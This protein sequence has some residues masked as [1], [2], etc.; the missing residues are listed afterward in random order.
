MADWNA[1]YPAQQRRDLIVLVLVLV[2]EIGEI[3][4]ED[5]DEGEDGVAK[6][7]RVL[8]EFRG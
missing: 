6:H 2:I 8:D 5:E 3:E 7:I 1:K 4:D